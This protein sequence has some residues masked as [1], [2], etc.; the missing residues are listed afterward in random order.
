MKSKRIKERRE[1]VRFSI[2]VS[3]GR[4]GGKEWE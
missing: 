3:M 2:V 4:G 1:G